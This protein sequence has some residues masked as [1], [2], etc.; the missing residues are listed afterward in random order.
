MSHRTGLLPVTLLPLEERN[1]GS[2]E[3]L[4]VVA[5]PNALLLMSV[6]EELLAG[7]GGYRSLPRPLRVASRTL[8]D[9]LHILIC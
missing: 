4:L 6:Y 5:A 7:A 8:L 3:C 2:G 9:D 1:L